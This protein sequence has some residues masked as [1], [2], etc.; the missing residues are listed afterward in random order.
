VLKAMKR[1]GNIDKIVERIKKWR[2]AVPELTIRSTFIVGFPGET[3]EDFELLLQFLR[4]AQLDRVGAFK[5]EPVKGAP[6]N[7]IVGAIPEDVK[8]F[9]YDRFME[10]Q[11]EISA[12]RLQAKIGRTLKV[13]IDEA[14]G[15]GGADGRSMAD[16][17]EIDGSVK[18]LPPEKA[19]KTLKVGE[20]TKARIVGA[21]GHDLVA[22]PI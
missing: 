22:Q 2:E 19:S 16:A 14:D 18:L 10:V 13:I 1:P 9:R 17:P 7:E 15:E 12:A 4:D 21:Q 8:Q 3:E 5:Y 6:A 11:Q 20:F